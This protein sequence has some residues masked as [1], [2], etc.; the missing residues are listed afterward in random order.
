MVQRYLEENEKSCLVRV[1]NFKLGCFGGKLR[2]L[3][4]EN[5]AK[6]GLGV[7]LKKLYLLLMVRVFNPDTFI[8]ASIIIAGNDRSLPLQWDTVR[9]FTRLRYGLTCK[10]CT[11][12][13]KLRRDKKLWLFAF[14]IS[15]KREQVFEQ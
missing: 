8:Q 14:T 11:S 6:I 5:S 3:V 7:N 15:S 2:T 13:N 9:C 12:L 10:Q 4:V 1:F